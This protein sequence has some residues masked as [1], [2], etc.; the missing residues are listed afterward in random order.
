MAQNNYP[1]KKEIIDVLLKEDP[2]QK[3]ME[4]LLLVVEHKKINERLGFVK[5]E[6]MKDGKVVL[7]G[8]MTA[9]PKKSNDSFDWGIL[10]N[11]ESFFDGFSVD[12]GKET[13]GSMI[14]EGF[15][16]AIKEGKLPFF[17]K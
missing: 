10:N 8:R 4:K 5:G 15:K 13:I 11:G 6:I 17:Q 1:S 12:Y 2:K 3:N 14:K 16:K 9:M 7:K